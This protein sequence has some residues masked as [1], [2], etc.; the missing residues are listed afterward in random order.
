[1]NAIPKSRILE[2]R[3]AL[4]K[5]RSHAAAGTQ[6]PRHRRQLALLVLVSGLL[7]L[8]VELAEL[9]MWGHSV[10]FDGAT[11]GRSLL[12]ALPVVA[13]ALGDVWV[14]DHR[15]KIVP[16]FARLRFLFIMVCLLG[17]AGWLY[18][19]YDVRRELGIDFAVVRLA[20][21]GPLWFA[22]IIA[23]IRRYLRADDLPRA[24][25]A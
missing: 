14:F 5:A 21:L 9:F 19:L 13:I 8:I 2:R 4:E 1:M 22:T 10:A 6:V 18:W 12:S 25:A 17:V 3:N 24:W 15:P 7:G 20:A 16:G 11:A 23:G